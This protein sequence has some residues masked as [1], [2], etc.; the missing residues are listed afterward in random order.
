M[1]LTA[2]QEIEDRKVPFESVEQL[3]KRVVQNRIAL[4][5]N[6]EGRE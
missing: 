2:Q 5:L 4:F 1:G 6:A 3:H